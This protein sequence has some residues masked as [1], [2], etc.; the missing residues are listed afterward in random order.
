MESQQSKFM[1]YISQT[2]DVLY[3]V[4]AYI[5]PLNYPKVGK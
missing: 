2:L 5:Q 3:G 4:F 1:L